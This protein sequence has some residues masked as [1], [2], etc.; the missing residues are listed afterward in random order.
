[1]SKNTIAGLITPILT[2]F[3]NDNKL[4][5]SLVNPFLQFLS[6]HINGYFV[7]GSFGSGMMMETPERKRILE[8]VCASNATKEKMIIVHVG[9]TS[10]ASTVE[11]AAHAQEQGAQA[12]AA[13]VPYYYPH[14]DSAILAHFKTLLKA[15][16]LPVYLYDYPAYTNRKVGLELFEKLIALGVRGV[17]DTTGNLDAMKERLTRIPFSQCD[18]VIGT[19]SL[20]VPAYAMG[21]RGCISGLSNAFPELVAG[22]FNALKLNDEAQILKYQD[23]IKEARQLMSRYAKM[24]AIYAILALRGI[25]CGKARAP[26]GF[27]DAESR[28]SLRNAL[29]SMNLL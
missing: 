16:D 18:Y 5:E 1:M 23:V 19:E 17:K 20:L 13:V 14:T 27:L 8:L 25:D 10:T 4:A 9:T 6:P 26:F 7:C 2:P 11:L 21:I 22:L 12:I 29:F 28:E 24:E 15:T 3:T